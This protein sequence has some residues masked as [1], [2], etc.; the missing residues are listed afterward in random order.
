[1]IPATYVA[2]VREGIGP[3]QIIRYARQKEIRVDANL[4]HRLLGDALGDIQL[5]VKNINL[6]PGYSI[7]VVGEGKQ[8]AESFGNIFISLML[9]IV[10]V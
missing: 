9:A 5:K 8:Q 7:S 4:S 1:M 6:D 10:F 2:S 3:S